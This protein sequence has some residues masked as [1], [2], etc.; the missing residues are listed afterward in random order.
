ML[1]VLDEALSVSQSLAVCLLG[2][3]EKRADADAVEL[4]SVKV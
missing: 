3:R 1:C 4:I 2:A